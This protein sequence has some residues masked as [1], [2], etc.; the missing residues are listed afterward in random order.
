M[1]II[2]K[3][4]EIAA[5]P[6]TVREKFLDFPSIPSYTPNG[7]VGSI[8][9]APDKAP[10]AL[11]PGDKLTC[12]M[13]VNKMKFSPVVLENSPAVFSWRGSLPAGI[14]TGEH[15]FRF[16]EVE[17]GIKTR[18]VHEERFTGLLAGALM[19]RGWVSGWVGMREETEKGF[20]GFNE[21]FKAWVEGSE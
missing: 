16:E 12:V 9:P 13:G 20:E 17:G 1:Y 15:I 7:F 3:S 21:D 18:L 6:A 4:I 14:F 19:G 2:S 10:S 11:V 5:S 8:S